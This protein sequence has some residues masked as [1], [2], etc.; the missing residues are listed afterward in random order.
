MSHKIINV[1][2]GARWLLFLSSF[3]LFYITACNTGEPDNNSASDDW[4]A[5]ALPDLSQQPVEL[6]VAS[7]VNPRFKQLS[8]VQISNILSRSQQMVKQHFAID[9]VFSDVDTLSIK[10]LFGALSNELIDA[11]RDEVV[12]IDIIDK[13]LREEMQQSVFKTLKN[14]AGNKDNVIDFA[15]PYLLYAE[16]KPRDFIE[17]SYALVDTLIARL[18]YWHT[19]LAEDGRPVLLDDSF[20]QWVWWDS[21]GYSELP[22][23]IV[24]TNQ[25]VASAEKYA[26]DVHSSVRGGITAG[27]TTYNK[28]TPLSSYAYIMVYPMLNDSELLTRLRQDETYSDEQIV[29]YSAALL[30]HEIGHL[31]LHLGHPFGQKYCIMSPTVMLNYR[32]WY[33]QL[34]AERCAVG[35]N[36]DM[37]PG[38][39]NIDYNRRW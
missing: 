38:A 28:N 37:M 27:T 25:L 22:Y 21:L 9:I 4:A 5:V 19:E 16:K 26:M 33:D 12:D 36:S 35:S 6:R 32:H 8:D 24:I 3:L 23:D 17:L 20:N 7:V 13:Q 30:T 10:E 34:D 39:V 31:L 2:F 14:Y 15:Q 18:R 29:N 1:L 11:R